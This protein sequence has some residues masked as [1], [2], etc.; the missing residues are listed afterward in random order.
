[1][2]SGD[3]TEITFNHPTLGSGTISPKSNEDSTIDLGGMRTNDDA[4]M[5]DGAGR[6]ITQI[7]R[8]LWSVETTCASDIPNDI[9]KLVSDMAKNPEDADWTFT[10]VGDVVYAGKG[11][12]VG[13]LQMNGNTGVFTLK[14]AGGET[15]KKL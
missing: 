1:M 8:V 9:V 4:N 14:V 3:I 13:D 15:L 2:I 7:N 10:I 5:I 6:M 12:P 11:R